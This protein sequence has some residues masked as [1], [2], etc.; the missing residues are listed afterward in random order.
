MELYR[1]YSENIR[2]AAKARN[3]KIRDLSNAT[4]FAYEHIR[5]IWFSGT[6]KH[7]HV[8]L[9][10]SEECNALLCELLDLPTGP[11]WA[12]AEREKFAQKNGYAP[13]DLPDPMGQELS[14]L[15]SNLTDEHKSVLLTMGKSFAQ[16]AA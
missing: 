6:P 14:E 9:T 8:R 3:L 16:V 2:M 12:L 13:V 7:K 4:G 5:K 11:M 10:V 15:W 1:T